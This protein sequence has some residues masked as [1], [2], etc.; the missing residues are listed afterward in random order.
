MTHAAAACERFHFVT[1]QSRAIVEE[2]HHRKT[3]HI[4]MV[5]SEE[6][7]ERC[8]CT[9][10]HRAYVRFLT[11]EAREVVFSPRGG[12]WPSDPRVAERAAMM[13]LA[14]TEEDAMLVTGEQFSVERENLSSGDAQKFLKVEKVRDFSS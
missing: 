14:S 1:R 12:G 5:L 4:Q 8:D 2:F 13:G 11:G 10:E 3:A 7:W 6:K 9:K